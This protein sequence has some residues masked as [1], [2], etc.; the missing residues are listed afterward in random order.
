[1]FSLNLVEN[2]FSRYGLFVSLTLLLTGAMSVG[3]F[4]TARL[5][6]EWTPDRNLL[7]LPAE[8]A[9]RLVL[10]GAC[11]L[12]GWLSGLSPTQLGWVW[13]GETGMRLVWTGVLWGVLV[14]LVFALATRWFVAETGG[15]FYSTTLIDAIVPRTTRA[16]V[17]VA[18]AM[19]PVVLLEELLFRSL[20][21][22]GFAVILPTWLLLLGWGIL[23]GAMHSPQ[24]AWGMVGAGLAGVLFGVLFLRS[25]SLV[26]PAVAHYVA[27]MVQIGFVMYLRRT[28]TLPSAA[29]IAYRSGFMDT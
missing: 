27:N 7:L 24:G 9:L 5:L 23:F 12:L 29:L 11:V 22:G 16:A 1:M 4:A 10:I 19:V 25:G 20:L 8:N 14:A 2:L 18:L 17:L 26:T 3:T 13:G 15:R 6:R 21:L 28:A